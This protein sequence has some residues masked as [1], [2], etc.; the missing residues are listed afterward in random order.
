MAAAPAGEI[1]AWSYRNGQVCRAA[2]FCGTE[3]AIRL[4][5]AFGNSATEID[6]FFREEGIDIEF[7][8][9]G[10]IWGATCRRH[11]GSWSGILSGLA[12]HG[13]APFREVTAAE[14]TAMTAAVH[15]S[16]ASTIRPLPRFIPASWRAGC[17]G[18]C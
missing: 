13:L 9:D 5:H 18:S 1:P 15:F 17:A 3:G 11:V 10:W 12:Q 6:A 8:R 7:R 14:I 2:A 4:G 16:P